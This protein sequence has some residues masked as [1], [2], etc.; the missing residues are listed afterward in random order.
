[1]LPEVAPPAGPA[2]EQ[3]AAATRWGE[4]ATII[5]ALDEPELGQALAAL[6]E[7]AGIA[8]LRQAAGRLRLANRDGKLA[9]WLLDAVAAAGHAT[10]AE[11]V[12]RPWSQVQPWLAHADAFLLAD[13][14]RARSGAGRG[15]AAAAAWMTA[16][17][18]RPREEIDP[19]SLLAG[20]DLMA[21]GVPEGKAVGEMLAALRTKQL[22]GE[23]I[24]REA[25][26]E[27][28]RQTG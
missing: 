22:D 13:F 9:T 5:E 12:S 8:P 2:P 3:A 19:P 18:E 10:A 4:A 6:F 1:V 28:V 11:L 17:L 14:L 27:W 23:I 21:A 25:A 15:D 20:R 26:L 24:S 16:Q 7:P